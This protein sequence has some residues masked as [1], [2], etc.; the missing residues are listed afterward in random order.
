[1]VYEYDGTKFEIRVLPA[2]TSLSQAK[3]QGGLKLVVTGTS[4]EAEK[5]VFKIGGKECTIVD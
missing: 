1:M 3:G 5:T 4:L 2:I